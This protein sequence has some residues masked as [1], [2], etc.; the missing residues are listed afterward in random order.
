MTRQRLSRTTK[1]VAIVYASAIV[2][3]ILLRVV[4]PGPDSVVYQTYK[5]IIP[6]IIALPA[7]YL[8]QAFQRRSSYVQGLRTVWGNMVGAVAASLA[9]TELPSPPKEQFVDVLRRLSA[10]IEEIRGFYANVPSGISSTGWYPFEPVKQ[11]HGVVRT[12]G[13]GDSATAERRA[14]AN[15]EIY[16]MWRKVRERFVAELEVEVPTYHHTAYAPG[17]VA[18]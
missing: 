5:D 18:R 9:Y 8:A 6:L 3:A 2:V 12:L 11:I 17:L 14:E 7:A 1:R 15:A 13:F 10:S 4:F 16:D